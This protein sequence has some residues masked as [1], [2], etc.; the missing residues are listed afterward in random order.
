MTQPPLDMHAHLDTSTAS[1]DLDSLQAVVFAATRSLAEATTAMGR[2]DHRI[3]WG[4]GCHP[5]LAQAHATFDAGLFADLTAETAFVSEVGLDGASPVP[6]ATQRATLHAIFAALASSPRITSL[7]S[8][9]ASEE[10]IAALAAHPIRGAVLHWW[11]GDASQT[12]RALDLGCYFSVNAASVR[13]TDL[14]DI[15][16][17]DRL[18]TETDHPYG[19]RRAGRTARP[20]GVDSVEATLAR[21]YGIEAPIVRK[22]MW[23]NLGRLVADIDCASLLPRRIRLQVIAS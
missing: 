8:Y 23:S 16:P 9:Q 2:A 21:H 5:R 14:L 11:L 17:L 22:R 12:R 4:V 15:I 20:G 19:D 18:L 6:M 13:R 7:H 3:C 10:V 1:R